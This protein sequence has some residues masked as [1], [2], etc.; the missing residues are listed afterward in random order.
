MKAV[1][2]KQDVHYAS[3]QIVISADH[4][5]QEYN[6]ACKRFSQRLNIPG[7]RRG[8][9]PRAVIEKNV[10]VERLKQEAIERILPPAFADAISEHQLDT[11]ASPVVESLSFDF[12]EGISVKAKV[13]LRPEVTLPA[14]LTALSA[15]VGEVSI[16]DDAEEREIKTI[17]EKQT[18]LKAIIDRP[19]EITDTVSVDFVGTANGEPI[20]GGAAKGYS[21]DLSNNNFIDGFAVQIPG[22]R[23]GEEFTIKVTFPQDYHDAALSGKPAEFVV[24]INEIKV[25][26]TPDL[27]DELAKKVG[28]YQTVDEL[29]LGIRNALTEAKVQQGDNR[30]QKAVI[31]AVVEASS[32]D[33]SKAMIDREAQLLLEEVKQRFQSQGLPWEQFMEAQGQEQIL[34]NLQ[35]E[36][37]KR[38]KTSLVF[39]AIS[40]AQAIAVSDDEFSAEIK[41]L[42]DSRNVDDKQIMRQLA[43]NPNAVQA[44]LNHLLGQ[45]VVAYLLEKVP[46][47]VVPESELPQL[48]K[49]IEPV[50]AVDGETKLEETEVAAKPI[51][52]AAKAK[53]SKT[54]VEEKTQVVT[55]VE[56]YDVVAVE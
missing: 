34:K 56:E 51:K 32:V 23:I 44:F 27:T 20:K 25:K 22:H 41:T 35:E 28:P 12:I 8:K 16:P 53:L 55:P 17:L 18:T 46:V 48:E 42:S 37:A 11:V 13:E 36:A 40:K 21:L 45:K 47:K 30:K 1:V 15:L 50:V 3:I 54:P 49:P 19:A 9:A 52:K 4:A 14:D 33:I 39:G 10:G 7:F 43:N 26:V 6:R 24:K 38:V 31:D 29:R 2:E 5:S